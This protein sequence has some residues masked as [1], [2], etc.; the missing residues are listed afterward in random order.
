MSYEDWKETF[1]DDDLKSFYNSSL[2]RSISNLYLF[3]SKLEDLKKTG[4]LTESMKKDAINIA[5]VNLMDDLR[6]NHPE[7]A[8]PLIYGKD[9][10]ETNGLLKFFNEVKI[11]RSNFPLLGSWQEEISYSRHNVSLSQMNSSCKTFNAFA[12]VVSDAEYLKTIDFNIFFPL[13]DSDKKEIKFYGN[14]ENYYKCIGNLFKANGRLKDYKTEYK[15][16]F[17]QILIKLSVNPSLLKIDDSNVKVLVKSLLDNSYVDIF[18]LLEKQITKHLSKK[19]VLGFQTAIL[20]SYPKWKEEGYD[21]SVFKRILEKVNI[22][23]ENFQKKSGVEID[24]IDSFSVIVNAD[25]LIQNFLSLRKRKCSNVEV[26]NEVRWFF[27]NKR[28]K[29]LDKEVDVLKDGN[30]NLFNLVSSVDLMEIG[31][32]SKVIINVL[33]P[34]SY[35]LGKEKVKEVILNELNLFLKNEKGISSDLAENFTE[36]LI[37]ETLMRKDLKDTGADVK[38]VSARVKKF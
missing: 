38:A 17:E 30:R 35:P 3:T 16:D 25:E 14:I 11:E 26:C 23:P 33:L 9:K 4:K 31:V 2:S 10:K 5:V 8:E 6:I 27:N 28:I 15:S 22:D 12:E 32:T 13:K 7:T 34:N 36:T 20:K 19:D 1:H 21:V 18:L 24:V 29:N 37:Q